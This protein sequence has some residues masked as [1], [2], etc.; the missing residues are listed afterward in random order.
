[1]EYPLNYS[2]SMSVPF[3]LGHM[4]GPNYWSLKKK[5]LQPC[6]SFTEESEDPGKLPFLNILV[7]WRENGSAGH[8]VYKKPIFTLM[9]Y[10]SITQ[11]INGR[12]LPLYSIEP[13]WSL[14]ENH[15]LRNSGISAGSSWQIGNSPWQ[16]QQATS[17]SSTK[18]KTSEVD[19]EIK[20]LVLELC[21]GSVSSKIGRMVCRLNKLH[22]WLRPVKDSL[23]LHM[24]VIHTIP[25]LSGK[26]SIRQK[27][28]IIP[29]Q[30]AE[31]SWYIWLRQP[32]KSGLAEHCIIN[33]HQ[34]DFNS[35]SI[36]AKSENIWSRVILEGIL[37]HLD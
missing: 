8:S 12:C 27:G 34:P 26:V 37:I 19:K 4:V 31:Y 14:M 35:T 36:L 16:I 2:E 29:E 28:C 10:V 7:F 25:G 21:H 24:P 22:H 33:G 32:E 13:G 11:N 15:C 6:I 3:W 20:K 5:K 17:R 23:G 1:M 18:R 9:P 30:I